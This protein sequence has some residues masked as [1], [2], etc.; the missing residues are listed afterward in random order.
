MF[1]AKL[2][3]E[4]ADRMGRS[5]VNRPVLRRLIATETASLRLRVRG[6]VT[7]QPGQEGIRRGFP[8]Q[9]LAFLYKLARAD[10]NLCYCEAVVGRPIDS[11]V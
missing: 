8:E 10:Q 3:G 4:R 9:L 7:I 11:A 1:S 5:G 2:S 6:F